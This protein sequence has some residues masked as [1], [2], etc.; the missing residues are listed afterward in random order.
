M[1]HTIESCAKAKLAIV[2][3]QYCCTVKAV[4]KGF[5]RL[6]RLNL[7]CGTKHFWGL[8]ERCEPDV[9][10]IL[11]IIGSKAMNFKIFHKP[12]PVPP[13]PFLQKSLSLRILQLSSQR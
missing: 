4:S 2:R 9:S 3:T 8:P 10:E 7:I 12:F 1:K 13:K 6:F 11:N 5:N